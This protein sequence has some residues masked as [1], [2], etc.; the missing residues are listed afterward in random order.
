VIVTSVL[1]ERQIAAMPQGQS[2]RPRE[3]RIRRQSLPH[4]I[5]DVPI[6]KSPQLF[7][8]ILKNNREIAEQRAVSAFINGLS[9][10]AGRAA[11]HGSN[12]L[13]RIA[14][15]ERQAKNLAL[16]IM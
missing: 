11:P 13:A 4:Y 15:G 7:E 1:D 2:N 3:P 10:F 9:P 14:A 6:R 8:I 5:A 16:D 12:S